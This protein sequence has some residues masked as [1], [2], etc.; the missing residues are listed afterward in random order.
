MKMTHKEYVE[1]QRKKAA[2]LA[3]GMLDGSVHYLEGAIALSSLRSEVDV[4]E[5]DEDFMAFELIASETDHLPVGASRQ[6]WSKETL[7]RHEPAIQKSI[8]WA[9][10]FSLPH[11]QSLAGRFG[12]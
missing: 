2:E 3:R 9:K 10:G 7:A 8:E 6:Y 4:A 5:D 1:K 12:V 11:C